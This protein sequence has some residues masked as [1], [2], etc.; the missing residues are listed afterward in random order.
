MTDVK[1]WGGVRSDVGVSRVNAAKSNYPAGLASRQG[2]SG[3]G[4]H[5]ALHGKSFSLGGRSN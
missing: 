5:R 1:G 3:I 4:R 2:W